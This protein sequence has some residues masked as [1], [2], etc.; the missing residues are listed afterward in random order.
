[1][2]YP[3]R[4]TAAIDDDFVLFII[5]MR[6]NKLWKPHKWMPV[7]YSMGRML[8]ELYANPDLGLIHHEQWFGRTTI[9]IQYS[10]SFEQLESYAKNQTAVHLPVWADFNK[11]VGQSG[12]VGI[13]HET[14]LSG[15]GKY[16]CVY[17]NM[18]LFGLGKVGEHVEAQG[19]F[20]SATERVKATAGQ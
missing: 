5:G 1:M 7:A 14:Y 6:V 10:R 4:M 2:I 9:M 13:W 19:K 3:K 20:R 11:K 16:E 12:D 17:N 18:P 8:N 15:K